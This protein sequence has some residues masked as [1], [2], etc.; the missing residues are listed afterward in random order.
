[1]SFHNILAHDIFDIL[2]QIVDAVERAESKEFPLWDVHS[3]DFRVLV[4]GTSHI[5]NRS[6][7]IYRPPNLMSVPSFIG[8]GPGLPGRR[9]VPSRSLPCP[10]EDAEWEDLGR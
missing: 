1:M 7:S 4:S 9:L 6:I 2:Q 3:A 10:P 5:K 8:F